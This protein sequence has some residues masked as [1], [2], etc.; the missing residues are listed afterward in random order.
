MCSAGI[1]F[2]HQYKN[3]MDNLYVG[4]PDKTVNF[5]KKEPQLI[6]SLKQTPD[7]VIVFKR[8]NYR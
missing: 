5:T 6:I 1:L 7:V 2:K 4:I 8:L 3:V